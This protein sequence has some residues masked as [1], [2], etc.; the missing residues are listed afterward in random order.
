MAI[1]RSELLLARFAR[2]PKASAFAVD[3]V[4]SAASAG[5]AP[6]L[7]AS[8]ATSMSPR[9]KFMRAPAE[10]SLA[11]VGPSLIKATRGATAPCFTII[12]EYSGQ[13]LARFK[14]APAACVLTSG[15]Y[16]GFSSSHNLG[17]ASAWTMA[18]R[19]SF[20]IVTCIRAPAAFSC[21]MSEGLFSSSVNL[22]TTPS[23]TK[24]ALFSSC[25]TVRF[26]IAYA[27]SCAGPTS[28]PL[29][30]MLTRAGKMPSNLATLS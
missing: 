6:A 27:A 7:A 15:S 8:A 30:R 16:V 25:P 22:G 5:I 13:S 26:Q 12:L 23:L 20:D 29:P 3:F 19:A 24:I 9:S 11:R 10:Y 14:S 28:S 2:A 17:M 1:C 4:R 18:T 21:A